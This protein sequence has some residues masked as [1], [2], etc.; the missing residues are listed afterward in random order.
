M[1]SHGC[2]LTRNT[3]HSATITKNAVSVVRNEF[4]ARFVELSSSV[5]LSNGKANCVGKTLS[6]RSRRHLNTRCIVSFGMTRC[7]AVNLTELL[8]IFHANLVPEQMEECILEHASMSIPVTELA[9]NFNL[10]MSTLFGG[11]KDSQKYLRAS[12]TI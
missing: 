6:K 8:K 2:C 7:D 10:L 4:E 9:L 1:T 11:D 5:C 12:I 3:L